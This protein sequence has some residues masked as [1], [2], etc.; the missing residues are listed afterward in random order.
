MILHDIHFVDAYMHINRSE[1]CNNITDVIGRVKDGCELCPKNKK[2]WP[3]CLV[4]N[5]IFYHYSHTQLSPLSKNKVIINTCI[6]FIKW[7]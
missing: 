7:V 2:G 5:E 1:H 3:Y 4:D 6:E